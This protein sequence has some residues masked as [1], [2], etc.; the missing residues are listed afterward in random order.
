MLADPE[1]QK[2][3]EGYGCVA[4]ASSPQELGTIVANEVPKW[5]ELV[6]SGRIVTQ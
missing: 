2:K 3:F 4:T 6:K 5:A 1:L